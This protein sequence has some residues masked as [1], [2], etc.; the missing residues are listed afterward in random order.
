MPSLCIDTPSHDISYLDSSSV[1]TVDPH[2]FGRYVID[3]GT[4]KNCVDSTT[5][6]RQVACTTV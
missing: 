3:T 1:C 5:I 2:S 4:D 6:G